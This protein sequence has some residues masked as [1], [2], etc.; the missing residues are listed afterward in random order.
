MVKKLFIIT[1]AVMVLITSV[2]AGDGGYRS[3]FALGM[4]ARQLGMGGTGVAGVSSSDAL[5]WNPAGLA[6]VDRNELQLF[7]MTLFMDTRYDYPTLSLGAFGLGIGDLSSGNFDRIDDFVNDGTFSSRQDIFLV[8][9][10]FPLFKNLYTGMSV[11]GVYY[12]I[13]GY[14]DSGFGFD[15][16]M[17]YN[18]ALMDGLSIGLRG[19]D[20]GGPT[21]KLNTVEQRYPYTIRGGLAYDKLL[22]QKHSLALAVD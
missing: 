16:G 1:A 9:Y 13:A 14:R 12:D 3:P 4:G 2:Y 5:Y 17:I 10:G 8:G 11:K 7:H 20:I 18:N 21:I 6:K 22:G 15:F 19:G